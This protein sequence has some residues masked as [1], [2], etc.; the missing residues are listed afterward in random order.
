M[1]HNGVILRC[2]TCNAKNRIP[3]HRLYDRPV[4]GKCRTPLPTNMHPGRPIDITDGTFKT[5][6]LT[7][8]VPVVVD[9]WAPWCGPCRLI[10][11]I[12]DQ[13]A[14]EYAGRI[15]IAKLNVDENPL[16]A[17]QFD[18]RSIPTMLFFKN[19]M[20]VNRLVGA[21]PKAAIEQ[22]LLSLIE[23]S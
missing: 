1:D 4:C 11:P 20:L 17:S 14:S 18:T 15:K 5:E 23:K 21:L 19:G 16:T 13:L 2:P 22:Q 8:P 6:V 7:A 3:E 12:L 9:C 10:A